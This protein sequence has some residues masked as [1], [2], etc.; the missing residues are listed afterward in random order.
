MKLDPR[1]RL[2]VALDVPS[3]AEAEALVARLG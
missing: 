2:I 1:D 3:V